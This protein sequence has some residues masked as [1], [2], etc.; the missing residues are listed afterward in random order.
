VGYL[1]DDDLDQ[2]PPELPEGDR[3]VL[4]TMH[5]LGLGADEAIVA[6]A[7][8]RRPLDGPR[9]ADDSTLAVGTKVLPP[10]KP[11]AGQPRRTGQTEPSSRG[12]DRSH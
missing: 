11:A 3:L 6:L 4:A 10:L 2:V 7:N 5:R 9:E 12:R 1:A 8:Y